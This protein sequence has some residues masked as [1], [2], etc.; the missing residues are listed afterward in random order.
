[1]YIETGVAP[2]VK[3]LAL[4]SRTGAHGG[5]AS[6]VACQLAS[7]IGGSTEIRAEHWTAE[8][9]PPY[10]RKSVRQGALNGYI[11]R[12]S[13][14]ISR[15]TGF[16]DLTT[17][18]SGPTCED[19]LPYDLYHFH[20]IS[21]AISPRTIK[22]LAK[23]SP[24][25]WTFHDCSPFTGGCIHPL[26]CTSFIAGCSNC[27]QLGRWP[28][29]TSI[30]RTG[31]LQQYKIRMVNENL[32]AI[33]CPSKWIADEAMRAGI[34]KN[35]IHVIHNAVDTKLF[36]PMEKRRIREKLGFPLDG[37][38]ILLASVD[39]L[40][41]FKGLKYALQA[42]SLQKIRLN[43]L[44][45]GNMKEK[46]VLP[47]MHNY[48]IREFTP[49][50]TL[51]ADYYAASDVFLLPSI[52]ENFPLVLLESM[53]SG[54]PVVAFDVGGIKEALTH[55]FDGWMASRG[56]ME[57]LAYGLDLMVSNEHLRLQ[58]SQNARVTTLRKFG[59]QRFLMSH[60]N[61]YKSLLSG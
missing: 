1:M 11:Y 19:G 47:E 28:Q 23:Y 33:V 39:V 60:L 3:K 16:V 12:A 48:I 55:Q 45:V 26:G 7:L 17:I 13:R 43:V 50:R 36:Q 25:V 24:V 20:D 61:L 34:S 54:T 46:L 22:Y 2:K 37:I 52:A 42:L 44:L 41:P 6:A 5:G 9:E 58:L 10:P 15:K 27:P 57:S 53:S 21:D 40:N 51:L 32:S 35:K 14:Y 49:D 8:P 4:V 30:D 18:T 38:L 29:M 59:E 56:D 31:F